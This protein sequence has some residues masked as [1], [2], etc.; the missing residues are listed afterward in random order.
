MPLTS[1]NPIEAL[2]LLIRT[3]AC[4]NSVIALLCRHID[5][6][7]VCYWNDLCFCP[8]NT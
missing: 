6:S 1:Y 5:R 2:V 4:P 8:V 3:R 7:T